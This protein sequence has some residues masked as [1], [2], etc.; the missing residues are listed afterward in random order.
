VEWFP[1]FG[2]SHVWGGVL[3]GV[4]EASLRVRPVL[5]SKMFGFFGD[6]LLSRQIMACFFIFQRLLGALTDHIPMVW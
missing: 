4:G 5:F 6:V 3:P 1:V 2:N